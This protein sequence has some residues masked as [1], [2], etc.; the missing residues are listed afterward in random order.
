MTK[1]TIYYIDQL[2][3]IIYTKGIDSYTL[4]NK[5]SK[6]EESINNDKLSNN[7]LAILYSAT[8]MAKSSFDYWEK[9]IQKWNNLKNKTTIQQK[10]EGPSPWT[11]IAAADVS[12]AVGGAVYAVVMNVIPGAGQVAYG[13]TILATGLG[14]SATTA[15]SLL[16]HYIVD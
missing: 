10:L 16:W 7:E 4:K 2:K 12:G 8:N 14:A 6:L 1:K 9:N 3:N 5:V 13:A 15:V 11:T